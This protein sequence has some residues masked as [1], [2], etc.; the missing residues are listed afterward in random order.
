[1]SERINKK[2]LKK[3]CIE[4]GKNTRRIISN[5]TLEKLKEKPSQSSMNRIVDEG[6]LIQDPHSI[7]L[8]DFWGNRTIGGLITIP[9]TDHHL[10]HLPKCLEIKKALKSAEPQQCRKGSII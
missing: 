1:M 4:V 7:W 2:E 10:M 8:K 3:Y 9:L 5:I 6:G